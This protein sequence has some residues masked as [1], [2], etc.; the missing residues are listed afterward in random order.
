M[1][2]FPVINRKLNKFTYKLVPRLN[3]VPLETEETFLAIKEITNSQ[4]STVKLIPF[5]NPAGL[6]SET[7]TLRYGINRFDERDSETLINL[8]ELL[9][10]ESSY[11]SSLGED[12]LI[13]HIREL[14]QVLARIEDKVKM[15]LKNQ[16]PYPYLAI[17]PKPEG[18]NIQVEFWSCHGEQAN[19]IPMGSRLLPYKSSHVA[20][21]SIFLITPTFGGKDK[22]NDSEKIDQYK[23]SLLTHDRIVTM[24][25]LRSFMQTELDKTRGPL[26]IKRPLKQAGRRPGVGFTVV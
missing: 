9:R 21:N 23:K 13:Q 7:Y 19:K 18:E 5:A 15:Q 12:F 10:E 11:F 8:T 17:K 2:A 3:I 16:S 22:F 6:P 25:D 20:T 26:L 14:N 24:E 4:G 1:N